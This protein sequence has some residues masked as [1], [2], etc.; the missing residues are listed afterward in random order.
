MKI[1]VTGGA[2]FIGTNFIRMVLA[3]HPDN[4]IINLDKITYAGNTENLSDLSDNPRYRF[5]LGDICQPEHVE[6]VMM[7]IDAVVHFAGETH[8]DRSIQDAAPFVVTNIFGTQ[9]LLDFA[10][11]A[12]VSRFIYISSDQIGGSLLPGIYLRENSP[13][14]PTNPYAASKASAEHLVYSAHNIHQFPTVIARLSTCFGPYQYPEKLIPLIIANALEFKPLPIYGD[15]LHV[16]DWIYVEDA[17]Q[18]IYQL[19]IKGRPGQIYN[20]GARSEKTNLEV[21][22][23][24]LKLLDRPEKIITFVSDRLGHDR[25]YAIDPGKI[26]REL[27]WHSQV[28]FEDGLRRTIDWYLR[29]IEWLAETRSG[30][31]RE[32][33]E[34]TYSNRFSVKPT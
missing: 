22:K 28:E 3:N 4:E 31:Y 24:I 1:L 21:V 11:D 15:G 26:E 10:R 8:V 30:S 2:G 12:G 14:A 27:G 17:C 25:R 20:I 16:R 32:Y 33:Y 5:Y 6:Q 29:N 9:L 34:N 19:L 18:A 23:R 7:G 13:A